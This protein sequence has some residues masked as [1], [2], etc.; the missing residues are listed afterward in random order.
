MVHSSGWRIGF[1][2]GVMLTITHFTYAQQNV[3]SIIGTVKDPTGAVASCSR[4][5]GGLAPAQT[6]PWTPHTRGPRSVRLSNFVLCHTVGQ[7]RSCSSLSE[8]RSPRPPGAS[9]ESQCTCARGP[10]SDALRESDILSAGPRHGR[11]LPIA[12]ASCRRQ[13]CVA[14][15]SQSHNA[16]VLGTATVYYRWHPLFGRSLRV[17][18]RMKDRHGEHLICNVLTRPSVLFPVG[19][20]IWSAPRSPWDNRRLPLRRSASS[21]IS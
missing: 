13:P 1:V 5:T 19:C 9:G 20:S 18:K 14:A 17:V 8:T 16:Y 10:A 12:G 6:P 11:F 3:G 2:V 7:L 21:G 15:S 4:C